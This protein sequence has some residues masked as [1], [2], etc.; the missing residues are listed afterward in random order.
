MTFLSAKN[1]KNILSENIRDYFF[2]VA[3]LLGD[4]LVKKSIVVWQRRTEILRTVCL[5]LRLWL[6][7]PGIMRL[8]YKNGH[9]C[10]GK[11]RQC[12]DISLKV[13][14]SRFEFFDP[15]VVAASLGLGFSVAGF[16]K[17]E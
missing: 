11:L 5:S 4:V 2:L 13:P 3:N 17:V 8:E 15:L 16:S 10:L 12:R 1:C 6:G 14:F 9:S 7:A